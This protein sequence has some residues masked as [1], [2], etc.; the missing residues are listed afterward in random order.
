MVDVGVNLEAWTIREQE[1][2]SSRC[3]L[4]DLSSNW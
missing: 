4:R 2:D 3:A 1:N